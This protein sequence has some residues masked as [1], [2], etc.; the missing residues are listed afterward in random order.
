MLGVCTQGDDMMMILELATRGDL[1]SF[2]RDCKP[3]GNTESLLSVAQ[4]VKMAI[5]I[6]NGMVFLS[7]M[8]FVHR[9]LACRYSCLVIELFS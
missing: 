6:A 4:R 5:D 8:Q 9:D 7:T 3:V 2:L 1:H